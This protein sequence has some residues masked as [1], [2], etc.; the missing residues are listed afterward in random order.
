MKKI[1]VL[2]YITLW[3]T[4]AF[5]QKSDGEHLNG[6]FYKSIPKKLNIKDKIILENKTPYLILQAVVAIV[7][8]N[9]DFIPL[10]N[11]TLVSPNETCE[12]VSY[13]DNGLKHLR[14]QRIA[15]KVKGSKK[16]VSTNSTRV[17]TPYGSVGV[18][19]QDLNSEILNNIK[20]EDIIYDFDAVL[21]E[22]NHDLYIQVM[23]IGEGGKNIMDF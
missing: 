7:D 21:Y 1:I 16:I 19:H 14:G 15:I 8:N 13:K 9:G 22:A 6:V 5:A 17:N 2:L 3:S 4:I 23:Y 11:T 12:I 10:A 20:P 18:H